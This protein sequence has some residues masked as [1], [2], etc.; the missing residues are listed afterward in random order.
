MSVTV[1]RACWRALARFGVR[2]NSGVRFGVLDDALLRKN[3]GAEALWFGGE[4]RNR[5][6]LV[7]FPT[8]TH[9]IQA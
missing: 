3:L 1:L 9:S 8:A 4:G 6:T 2:N 7:T 5:T